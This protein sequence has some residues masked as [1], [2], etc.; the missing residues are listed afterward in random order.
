MFLG[1]ANGNMF[2]GWMPWR[3]AALSS[4]KE[5]F[6]SLFCVVIL[7]GTLD[8]SLIIYLF[9]PSTVGNFSYM[10]KDVGF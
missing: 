8:K 10:L 6:R 5:I 9:I 7:S 4:Y 1:M 3:L 2:W